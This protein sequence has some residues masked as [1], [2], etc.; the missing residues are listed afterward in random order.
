MSDPTFDA[1]HAVRCLR[2]AIDIAEIDLPDWIRERLD[3]ALAATAK[4][5]T[6]RE[7]YRAGICRL[8]NMARDTEGY[9]PSWFDRHSIES[10]TLR[11][12]EQ[13]GEEEA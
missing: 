7:T 4:A 2:L 13:A 9:G 10:Y 1:V 6:H 5:A 3:A 12:I 11:V 8:H